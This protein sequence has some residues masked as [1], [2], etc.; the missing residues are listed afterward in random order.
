VKTTR[1]IAEAAVI[2]ALYAALTILLAPVS[3]L[4]VQVRVAEALTV[5][6][7]FASSAIPGLFVGCIIANLYAFLLVGGLAWVDVI[8]GSMATLLAAYLSRKM[9]KRWLVP[10]PPVVVNGIVVGLVLNY[11]YKA[12]LL[13]TMGTVTLGQAI[14]CYGLGY[15][16][17]LLIDKHKEKIFKRS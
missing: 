9:P 5:L 7:M 13:L 1:F 12:P 3:F 6:P 8:F 15:P 11:V 10:L 2:A 14:A 16:L 4:P 17:I